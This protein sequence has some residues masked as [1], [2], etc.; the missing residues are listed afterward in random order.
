MYI[1]A[2]IHCCILKRNISSTMCSIYVYVCIYMCT[3]TNIHVYIFIYLCLCICIY[4][5]IFIHIYIYINISTYICI[6]ICNII[7]GGKH[8]ST[9]PH[10]VRG[11]FLCQCNHP[12]GEP[13]KLFDILLATSQRDT[14]IYTYICIYMYIYILTFGRK[15]TG[16]QQMNHWCGV[17]G[18][19]ES[20]CDNAIIL[21]IYLY[22]YKYVHIY[23]YIYIYI[24]TYMHM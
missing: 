3:Y 19:Q 14:Y 11:I 2:H 1:Y 12:R 4:R 20:I 13:L 10:D 22:S 5:Y 24:Y 21:C 17:W 15:T 6:Y 9:A 23:I 16:S 8:I 7:F 18:I